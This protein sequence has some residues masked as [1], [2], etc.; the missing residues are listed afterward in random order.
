[1][2]LGQLDPLPIGLGGSDATAP[3]RRLMWPKA[4]D[5]GCS[6]S[7]AN[8]GL[9]RPS[10]QGGRH[11]GP[12]RPIQSRLTLTEPR[13]WGT[14]HTG[15]S[16]R[17]N[18]CAEIL[19]IHRLAARCAADRRRRR[20]RQGGA[21]VA[22]ELSGS[23]PAVS[24]HAEPDRQSHKLGR[25]SRRCQPSEMVR[26]FSGPFCSAVTRIGRWAGRSVLGATFQPTR[27]WASFKASVIESL[28]LWQ[29]L[30]AV[31]SCG[32]LQ[33]HRRVPTGA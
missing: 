18:L 6:K 7:A 31:R 29:K 17:Q 10:N 9:H 33:S 26:R 20:R 32:I 27:S 2:A 25:F 16:T 15:P 23:K 5:V 1:M 8:L 12:R 19:K 24:L 21:R 28:P 22:E 30:P 14:S 3:E 4:A 13:R 11:S